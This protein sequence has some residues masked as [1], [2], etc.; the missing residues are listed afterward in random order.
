MFVQLPQR[1]CHE[2]NKA[3]LSGRMQKHA[4]QDQ[5]PFTKCINWKEWHHKNYD[6]HVS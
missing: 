5:G 1:E 4:Q 2:A 6:S 3:S